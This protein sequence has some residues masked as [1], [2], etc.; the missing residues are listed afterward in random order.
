MG[1][2]MIFDATVTFGNILEILVIAG[3]GLIALGSM[4][5]TVSEMRQEQKL[6]KSDFADMKNEIKKVGDVLVKIAVTDQRLLN[7]EQDIR[8][9]KHGRGFIQEEIKGEYPRT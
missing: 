9:I 2:Y 4:K 6:M 1:V 3:G 5:A 8:E 7:V